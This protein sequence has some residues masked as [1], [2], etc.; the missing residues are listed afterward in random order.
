MSPLTPPTFEE[1]P[2]WPGVLGNHAPT[3]VRQGTLAMRFQRVAAEGAGRI[4]PASAAQA[5]GEALYPYPPDAVKFIEQ[6]PPP[7]PGLLPPAKE[8]GFRMVGI[9]LFSENSAKLLQTPLAKVS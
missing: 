9:F 3:S 8:T 6:A 7:G 2:A 4:L 1:A 5:I